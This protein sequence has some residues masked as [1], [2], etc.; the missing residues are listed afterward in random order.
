MRASVVRAYGTLTR[1][2][3]HSLHTKA[4]AR[5]D[6]RIRTTLRTAALHLSRH[7]TKTLNIEPYCTANRFIPIQLMCNRMSIFAKENL[8]VFLLNP[9]FTSKIGFSCENIK[10]D[11]SSENSRMFPTSDYRRVVLLTNARRPDAYFKMVDNQLSPKPGAFPA[12]QVGQRIV[13]RR[14]PPL[15]ARART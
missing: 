2:H 5:G 6:T 9:I 8:K 15:I 4:N 14:K 7:R 13:A 12:F 10:P 3:S 1:V 11:I